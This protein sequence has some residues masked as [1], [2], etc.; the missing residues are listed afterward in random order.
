[1]KVNIPRILVKGV[2]IFTKYFDDNKMVLVC[3]GYNDDYVNYTGLYWDEDRDMDVRDGEYEDFQLWI[4][5]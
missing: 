1:M 4:R 3:K 5:R 2:L